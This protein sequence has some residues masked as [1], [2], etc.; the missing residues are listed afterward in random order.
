MMQSQGY[1]ILDK[2][3]LVYKLKKSLYNLKQA[4]RKW[5]LKFNRFM[6]S[7]GYMRPQLIIVAIFENSYIILL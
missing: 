1:I 2:K 6:A 4:P 5:Y 3:H 7:G